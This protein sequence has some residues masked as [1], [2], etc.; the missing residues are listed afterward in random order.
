MKN[1]TLIKNSNIIN[2][3]KNFVADVLIEDGI[4]ADIGNL[5]LAANCNIINATG[6]YLFPGIIDAHVHFRVPGFLTKLILKAKQRQPLREELPLI[7]KCL[8]QAPM[9]LLNIYW[10][11]NFNHKSHTLL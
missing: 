10:N 7:L 11:K 1:P 6:K 3:G 9:C 2:E 5:P 4:I 8:T